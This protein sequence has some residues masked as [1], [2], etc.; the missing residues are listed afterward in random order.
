MIHGHP[1]LELTI[2]IGGASDWGVIKL[3]IVWGLGLF[4][5]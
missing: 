3:K 4:T 1:D 2:F 5:Q